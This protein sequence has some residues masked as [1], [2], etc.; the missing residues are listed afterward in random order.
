M[1]NQQT[2][3]QGGDTYLA[4]LEAVAHALDVLSDAKS[5]AAR[6]FEGMPEAEYSEWHHTYSV[7]EQA[8]SV[9]AYTLV[10]NMISEYRKASA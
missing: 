10:L 7:G 5:E 9:S 1:S 3:A 6:K 8:G 4:A 2:T